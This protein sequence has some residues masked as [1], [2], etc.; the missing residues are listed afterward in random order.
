MSRIQTV[1]KIHEVKGPRL[2]YSSNQLAEAEENEIVHLSATGLAVAD[3]EGILYWVDSI[4]TT[5]AGSAKVQDN[6][7]ASGNVLAAAYKAKAPD[8]LLCNYDPPKVYKCG[9]Y[10]SITTGEVDIC[11]RPYARNLRCRVSPMHGDHTKDLVA[12]LTVRPVK[13][14]DLVS[15]LIVRPVT[16]KALVCKVTP[17]NIPK[18]KDL[19][20]KVIVRKSLDIYKSFTCQVLVTNVPRTKDL[21]CKVTVTSTKVT[22]DLVCQLTVLKVTGALLVCKLY[23]DQTP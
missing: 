3:G 6:T 19:V 1:L 4:I 9:L 15:K 20:S 23:A 16:G 22:N 13:T 12:R 11:Y 14:K 18:T 10:V 5:D 8:S 21:T 7:A 17:T 2:S